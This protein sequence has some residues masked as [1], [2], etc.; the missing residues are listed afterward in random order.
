MSISKI[1]FTTDSYTNNF[2]YNLILNQVVKWIK[3]EIDLYG[4]S[5]AFITA[6]NKDI[7]L[8]N[9]ILTKRPSYAKLLYKVK[10]MVRK[11]II[12]NSDE[13]SK[14]IIQQLKYNYEI[15]DNFEPY[16]KKQLEEFRVFF[17]E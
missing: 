12:W 16:L 15:P 4:G 6:Q 9:K 5:Q 11:N 2:I 17:F 13:M 8:L 14:Y 10:S 7:S 3:D 1:S